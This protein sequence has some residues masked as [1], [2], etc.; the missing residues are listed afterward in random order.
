MATY[1]HPGIYI[2]EV[3]STRSIQGASTSTAAFVGVTETGPFMQ[4]TLITSWNAYQRQFGNLAWYAMVSWSVYEF[5]NEGG[6]A[7]YIVRATDSANAKAA[8]GKASPLVFSAVTP[9]TWGNVLNIMISNGS[10]TD[11][12]VKSPPPTPVFNVTI[13]VDAAVIATTT[14]TMP[15]QLLQQ[16]VLEN[17]LS[18]KTIN[19]K[20][21]YVL[22]QFNGFTAN[23]LTSIADQPSPLAAKINSNS[24]FVRLPVSA[25][26][27]TG[28]RPPNSGPTLFT[29][30]TAPVYDL[31]AATD[32]L[33]K[34]QGLSLLS[35]PDTVTATDNG[36][37]PSQ[38]LQ[39]QL[40]NLGLGFCEK[41]RS[42]FYV[43]DPPFG[44]NL[45]DMLSFKS[46]QGTAPNGNPNALNSD[47]GAIYYPWVYIYNPI[48]NANVPI[49]PSGPVLGRYAY[50]DTNVG[51]YKS[52]AGVSDGALMTAV[53][54]DQS[55]TDADQ[56]QLNQEGINAIRNFINY[57]NVIWGARTLALNTEWT[58]I[59]VRRLFIY[60]EQSLK[61]SLQW[62]VFEPND[63][64]LWSSVT[65]DI[66][67]FL[68]TL[69]QQGGLFGA[70][71]SEAFFVTCDAS[72]NPPE[73]R[74]L[75]Q[76]YIDI[77]LAAVYPAEF[78]IIRM[79]QK[80]SAPDSGN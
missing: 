78:V 38:S 57:G 61:Q 26:A 79:T 24:M 64:Q 52:P 20:Q 44:L 39:G 73:T 60:V 41:L 68:T 32:L 5:F 47:F 71:A 50:T 49:P 54:L 70:T 69:W 2:Q 65:R 58:Y 22:E 76:L 74:M 77:G 29:G 51:V 72:N 8:T 75:G 34:V 11:P 21:Y 80:T 36:G 31:N 7:C 27:T 33:A 28:T 56:D 40:I 10:A 14:A 45:Q 42:L 67:A 55:I 13:L 1:N 18:P 12:T 53:L 16:Y 37:K 6:T 43:I 63:Q 25:S 48:A 19:S 23:S 46:G 3:P 9:G 17:N 4:P 35:V 15:N 66:S 62:V 59:A 30:G